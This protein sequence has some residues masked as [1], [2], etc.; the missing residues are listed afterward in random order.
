MKNA[1]QLNYCY[2]KRLKALPNLSG[3]VEL[4]WS[5]SA[6]KVDGT[7]LVEVN[8]TGDAELVTC[9]QQKVKRW[10]FPADF[11]GTPSFPFIFEAK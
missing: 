10:V 8:T 7:P 9:M 11:T 6:G 3:R 4:S 5:V 1:G 2:E